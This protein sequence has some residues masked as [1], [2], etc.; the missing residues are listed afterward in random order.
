MSELSGQAKFLLQKQIEAEFHKRHPTLWTPLYSMVTFSPNLPYSQALA[1]GD[2]QQKIM[3]EI[4]QIS[5]IENCW[6]EDF[7]YEKL[8]ELAQVSVSANHSHYTTD[9]KTGEQKN[10]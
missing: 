8:Q 9:S 10:D 2:I 6:Q 7:V 5:N 3:Q 4:M 1:I